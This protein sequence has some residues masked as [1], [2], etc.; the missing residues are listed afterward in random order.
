MK[1]IVVILAQ[2]RVLSS[3]KMILVIG[4]VLEIVPRGSPS[5]G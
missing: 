3:T 1:I 2:R 4:V 5:G